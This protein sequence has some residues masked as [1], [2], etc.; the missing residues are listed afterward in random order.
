[1]SA[2]NIIPG[3]NPRRLGWSQALIWSFV[4]H[5]DWQKQNEAELTF[6]P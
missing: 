2:K 5:S 3:G 4:F 6:D 1:M